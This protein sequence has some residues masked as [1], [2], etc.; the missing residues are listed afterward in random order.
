MRAILQVARHV[1]QQVHRPEQAKADEDD[2]DGYPI[3][4]LKAL[5]AVGIRNAGDLLGIGPG[6]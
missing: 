6:P 1:E 4:L 3:K 2:E 5:A